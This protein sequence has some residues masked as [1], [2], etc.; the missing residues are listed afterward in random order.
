MTWRIRSTISSWKI[1]RCSM[2][3]WRASWG[4]MGMGSDTWDWGVVGRVLTRRR[5]ASGGSRPALPLQEI[6]QQRM[7]MLGQD[8]LGMELHAFRSEEHTSELQSLMRN[9]YAVFCLKKKKQQHQ[10]E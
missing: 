8:R 6:L 3:R 1:S 9:S 5:E 10:K 2:V 7:S 4:V